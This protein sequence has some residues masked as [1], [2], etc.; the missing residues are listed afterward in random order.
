M[1]LPLSKCAASGRSA[2]QLGTTRVASGDAPA[3]LSRT[4]AVAS[5]TPDACLATTD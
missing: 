1:A 5:S 2:K 3:R 4:C